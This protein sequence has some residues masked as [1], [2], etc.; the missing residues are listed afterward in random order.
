MARFV[1]S[2]SRETTLAKELHDAT[3]A[4]IVGMFG[5]SE[6]PLLASSPDDPLAARVETSGRVCGANVQARVVDLV[7]GEEVPDGAE[8]ELRVKGASVIPAYLGIDSTD[9]YDPQG[10]LRTGDIAVRV[11]HEGVPYF[12]IVGRIKDTISRGGEKYLAVEMEQL[13]VAMPGIRE[14]AIVAHPDPLVGERGHAFIVLEAG[15]PQPDVAT[16]AAHLADLGVAKY[17]WPEL[18]TVVDELPRTSLGAIK[19]DKKALRKMSMSEARP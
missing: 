12:R 13:I 18:V 9:Y 19:V 1:W 4:T 17:K 3:G 2:A 8:G 6:G 16:I 15:A 10:F 11:V 5:M 14:A 7:S